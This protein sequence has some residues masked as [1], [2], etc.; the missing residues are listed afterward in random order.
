MTGTGWPLVCRMRVGREEVAGT[1]RQFACSFGSEEWS[2]RPGTGDFLAGH[3]LAIWSS[4]AETTLYI[5]NCTVYTVQRTQYTVQ[6]T[7]YRVQCSVFS[8]QCT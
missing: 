3:S 4:I 5:I 7:E 1:G 8:V 6:F 2:R